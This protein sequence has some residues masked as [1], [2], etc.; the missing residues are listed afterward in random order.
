MLENIIT[1][2]PRRCLIFLRN[3][4]STKHILL[5]MQ[6]YF[7]VGDS[8]SRDHRILLQM[9]KQLA[10]TLEARVAGYWTCRTSGALLLH[11][12]ILAFSYCSVGLQHNSL[13]SLNVHTENRLWS[14]REIEHM[15]VSG[16]VD[17]H[18]NQYRPPIRRFCDNLYIVC[19]WLFALVLCEVQVETCR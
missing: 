11:S 12:V 8:Q 15:D 2:Q 4:C 14:K 10:S 18:R 5:S 19:L 7:A 6:L 1:E 9:S 16:V 13:C 3:M 17:H